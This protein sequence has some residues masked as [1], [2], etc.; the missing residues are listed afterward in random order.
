MVQVNRRERRTSNSKPIFT[1]VLLTVVA[2]FSFGLGYVAGRKSVPSASAEVVSATPS[3]PVAVPKLD[4][5]IVVVEEKVEAENLSFFDALPRGEQQPLGSGVNL[6]PE[7]MDPVATK[8]AKHP[9]EDSPAPV[10][11][12]PVTVKSAVA[13]SKTVVSGPGV[14]HV[15]QVASFRS[16]DEAGILLRRLEKKGYQPYIQQADLGSKGVWFRVFLGP[17]TSQ[18]QAKLA[19]ISIKTKEKLDPLVRRSD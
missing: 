1:A 10:K 17:Y 15:L 11:V 3:Q 14:P 8:I 12:A 6:P 4:P 9:A 19:A 5:S 13:T 2:L 7:E 18:E 16:P